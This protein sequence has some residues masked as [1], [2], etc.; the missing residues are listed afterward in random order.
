MNDTPRHELWGLLAL[1]DPVSDQDDHADV[2]LM[3]PGW[4]RDR[5]EVDSGRVAPGASQALNHEG[6]KTLAGGDVNRP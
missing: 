1:V 6:R 5:R 4:L 2:G 3:Y